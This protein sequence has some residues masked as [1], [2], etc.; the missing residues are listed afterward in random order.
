VT[1]GFGR[2]GML[3]PASTERGTALHQ[4]G[5]DWSRDLATLTFDPEGHGTCGW[6]G[7]S[8]S[9]R[10]PSLKFA[11]LAVRKIWRTMCVSINGPGD[12]DF[13]PFELETGTQ[14]VSKIGYLPSKFGHAR[15]LGSWISRYVRDGRTDGRTDRQKQSL[16]PPFLLQIRRFC[17]FVF[18]F[19]SFF[20]SF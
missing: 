2:Y 13:W 15:P 1:A 19:F 3:L 10:V 6:C 5:S 12:L 4:D 7:S 8:S 11:G 16:L 18:L 17:C 14:V 20:L 9:I